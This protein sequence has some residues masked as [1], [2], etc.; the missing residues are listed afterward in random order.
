[1]DRAPVAKFIFEHLFLPPKL[2]QS[3]HDEL[4]ADELLKQVTIAAR[5]F[6]KALDPGNARRVWTH[7]ARSTEQWIDLYDAGNYCSSKITES[8][9]NMQTDSMDHHRHAR[10]TRLLID[11]RCSHVLRQVSERY[12]RGKTPR[13]WCNF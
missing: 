13:H 8:L 1:M 2:P 7:L 10:L 11:V 9:K 3:D 4:G 5:A 6:S 12:N